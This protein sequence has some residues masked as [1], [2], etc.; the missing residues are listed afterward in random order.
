MERL[1]PTRHPRVFFPEASDMNHGHAHGSRLGHQSLNIGHGGPPG[2]AAITWPF[3]DAL[4]ERHILVA[5]DGA[6][7]ID[8]DHG[9]PMTDADR[10]LTPMLLVFR[11][12]E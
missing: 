1:E 2:G 8:I 7:E 3:L 6:I 10:A 5:K 11:R 4:Q 12:Q 9:R